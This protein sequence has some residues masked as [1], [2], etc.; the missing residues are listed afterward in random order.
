MTTTTQLLKT[1]FRPALL[2]AVDAYTIERGGN[3]S[4]YT[5]EV[6][7]DGED[8]IVMQKSKSF[9]RLTIHVCTAREIKRTRQL[10]YTDMLKAVL[11]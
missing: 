8:Y 3:P 11:F 2:A 7:T 5:Y 9:D 1:N 10:A 4:D 6:Y